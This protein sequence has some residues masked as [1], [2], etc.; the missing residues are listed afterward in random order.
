VPKSYE[1]EIRDL[2]RGM[3][4]FPGEQ[5]PAKRRRGW[6]GLSG[7]RLPGRLDVQ[8]V[9]GG[10]LLLMLFSWL[11][12]GP[13]AHG[14]PALT[15]AAGYISLVSVVL[16]IGALVLMIRGGAFGAA[17]GMRPR[18][19]YW[20]G[21]VIELPRRGGPLAG[22]RRWLRRFQRGSGPRGRYPRGRDSIQW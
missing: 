6:G 16:F 7:L 3:D 15:T 21:Q 12:R 13:W 4:R 1:E 18:Q 20:R 14:Y 5:R 17:G 8:R 10:A 11:L 19:Q 2:L 22:L 9:M